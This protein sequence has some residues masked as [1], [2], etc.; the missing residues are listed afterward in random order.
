MDV[1]LPPPEGVEA[2]IEQ[3]DGFERLELLGANGEPASVISGKL[4]RGI[5][6]SAA[7]PAAIKHSTSMD[8]WKP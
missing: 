4:H 7:P 8:R 3:L 1:A 5:S 2:K 6:S